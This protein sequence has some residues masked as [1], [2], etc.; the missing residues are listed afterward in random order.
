LARKHTA[1]AV[2]RL[3]H[4]MRSDNASASVAAANALLDRG[5]GKPAQV[6]N[7]SI[8]DISRRLSELSPDDLAALKESLQQQHAA[9]QSAYA[10][11]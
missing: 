3:T 5:Y 1:E 9:E 8:E 4:W 2:E 11:H 6:V 7:L 10:R